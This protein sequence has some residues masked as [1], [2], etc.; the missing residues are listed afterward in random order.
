[1]SVLKKYHQLASVILLYP[2][3]EAPIAQMRQHVPPSTDHVVAGRWFTT[4]LECVRQGG[5]S[6]TR[7]IMFYFM[8]RLII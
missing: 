3:L 2:L 5:I 1:V 7:Y 4:G 8:P 6:A